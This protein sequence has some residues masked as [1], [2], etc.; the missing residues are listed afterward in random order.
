[1]EKKVR[2]ILSE[3]NDGRIA[4]SQ[5]TEQVLNLFSVSKC[6]LLADLLDEMNQTHCEYHADIVEGE[7]NNERGIA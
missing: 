4:V 3:L 7:M 1:M 6:V 2:K 5:A